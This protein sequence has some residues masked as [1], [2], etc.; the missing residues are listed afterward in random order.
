MTS[1]LPVSTR[2]CVHL[3]ETTLARNG[4]RM[5][6]YDEGAA[7]VMELD[8]IFLRLREMPAAEVAAVIA[9]VL[10]HPEGEPLALCLFQ[11]QYESRSDIDELLLADPRL[12]ALVELLPLGLTHF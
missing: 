3:L 11:R 2:E 1:Q 12:H 9:G 6:Y 10:E 4:A 5:E 8:D 7:S